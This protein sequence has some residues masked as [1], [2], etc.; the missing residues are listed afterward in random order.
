M[1]AK[2][3][4]EA[5]RKALKEITTP[6]VGST[7]TPVVVF[8]PLVSV[9]GVTGVFFRALAIT[10]TA[11]LLTSLALALT[12]TPGLSYVLLRE[13]GNRLTAHDAQLP[14]GAAGSRAAHARP[15][16]G[17]GA[18]QAA[19]GGRHL[20][21]AG[22]RHLGRLSDARLR[23]AAGNGRRRLHPRLHHARGQLAERDQPRARTRGANSARHA[24]SGDHLAP[25][26]PA[27]GPG[28]RDRGQH[29]R[30]HG[31]AEGQPQPLHRRSDGRR[32][33]AGSS[34]PSRSWTSSSR[35]CCRT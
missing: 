9:S 30:L 4:V 23:S 16:A 25:H 19:L 15:G 28:R 3:R 8:L 24:R 12:W 33:P 17:V 11:A 35:R 20:R 6:L 18:C 26:R 14:A 21:A 32:A 10:M 31:E 22:S 1:P 7:I 34:P 13:R 5:V 29:R 27:D 2:H